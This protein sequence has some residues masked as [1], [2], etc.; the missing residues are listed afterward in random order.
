M[1]RRPPAL[2]S[3]TIFISHSSK[4]IWIAKHIAADLQKKGGR[5][6]LDE[7]DMMSGEDIKKSLRENIQKCRKLVIL[8][9]SFSIKSWWV[10]WEIGLAEAFKK[11]IIPI[12]DK[13]ETNQVHPLIAPHKAIDLNDL[14][15][16]LA[17]IV[18]R[19]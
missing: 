17:S 14:D 13:V 6:F 19:T 18:K 7:T 2:D 9:S 15:K 11:R 4:D 8:V 16:Y 3:R 1:S 12:L 10:A 5:T